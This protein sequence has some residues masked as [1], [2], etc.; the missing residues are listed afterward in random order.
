MESKS[1]VFL[2]SISRKQ[3]ELETSHKKKVV[4][5]PEGARWQID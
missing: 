1:H 3:L 5:P 2:P 4:R